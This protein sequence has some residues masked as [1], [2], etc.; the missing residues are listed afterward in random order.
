MP[1]RTPPKQTLRT[2]TSIP[3]TRASREDGR[4]PR[5]TPVKEEKAHEVDLDIP[6][7]TLL[8]RPPRAPH[9]SAP[10][11]KTDA[12]AAALKR[13]SRTLTYA[14][15]ASTGNKSRPRPAARSECRTGACIKATPLCKCGCAYSTQGEEAPL[16]SA[17]EA[18]SPPTA[19]SHCQDPSPPPPPSRCSAAVRLWKTSICSGRPSLFSKPRSSS[20][21][22]PATA[23]SCHP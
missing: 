16:Q 11:T 7:S 15:D 18:I 9:L 1:A 23:S 12:P 4:F 8:C 14:P 17:G 10:Y 21:S 22:A 3:I 5:P 6:E 2:L 19:I 20:T 13:A